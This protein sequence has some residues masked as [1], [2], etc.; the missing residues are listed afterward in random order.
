MTT[1]KERLEKANQVEVGF[2]F[3]DE[4][5]D[6]AGEWETCAVGEV[7]NLK[8]EGLSMEQID[9]TVRDLNPVLH[10]LGYEFT[11]AVHD[12]DIDKAETLYYEIQEYKIKEAKQ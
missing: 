2:C 5:M 8:T 1:W 4:D 11:G 7:L 3:T 9:Q 12:G 10:N 6:M